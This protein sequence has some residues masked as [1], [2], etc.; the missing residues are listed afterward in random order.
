MLANTRTK[1]ENV[2]P[3][4]TKTQWHPAFTGA[5]HMEFRENK[6]DLEFQSEVVLNTMPLRVDMILIKKKKEAVLKN[7]IGKIF[8]QYNL[9]EYKSPKDSLNFNT[10]LKG[11]AYAYLY[12]SYEKHID[13]I[14]LSEVTL[15]FRRENPPKKL[16]KI[17]RKN[18]F[19]VAE[20]TKGI[21]YINRYCEFPIQ[22]IVTKELDEEQHVWINSLT[23]QISE[24]HIKK[25][26]MI[27]DDLTELDEKNYA[28][29]VWEVI[30]TENEI[31]MNQL[32]RTE[33]MYSAFAKIMKPEIDEAYD[34]GQLKKVFD[35]LKKG[36]ISYDVAM[37]ES[38][39]KKETFE[40]KY[41]EYLG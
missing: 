34:N 20:A 21:Y 25:L 23:S 9:L 22:I 39:L 16:F 3:E 27:T 33:E 26:I 38:E 35:F 30:T 14:P 31:L 5:I 8:K 4:D 12:K 13:D 28:N 24:Q 1:E 15:T 18:N 37:K 10:F 11:V 6:N 19:S 7:E 29:S 2:L 36:I 40:E 41:K 32:R 17:L